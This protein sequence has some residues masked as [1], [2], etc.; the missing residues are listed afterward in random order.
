MAAPFWNRTMSICRF[1]LLFSLAAFAARPQNPPAST[2]N[3]MYVGTLSKNILV[4]DEAQEKVVDQIPLHTGTP[5]G[6]T[7][8]YD[9][10][11]I[12]VSTWQDGIEVLDLAS[13]KVTQH[14]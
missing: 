7:L 11:K 8:S 3:L 1:A 12:Y 2:G 14:F 5:N 9:K 4:V 13:R 6:L 10:K